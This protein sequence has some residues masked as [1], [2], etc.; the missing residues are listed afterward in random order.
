VLL[1]WLYRLLED[2]EERVRRENDETVSP[3]RHW[4]KPGEFWLVGALSSSSPVAVTDAPSGGSGAK[5][6]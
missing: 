3:P 4:L 2:R 5:I 6:Q 1:T